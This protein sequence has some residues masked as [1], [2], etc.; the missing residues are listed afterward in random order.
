M[1]LVPDWADGRRPNRRAD[2]G[3]ITQVRD[4]RG[5]DRRQQV[6]VVAA[7]EEDERFTRV[8]DQTIVP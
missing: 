2:D 6:I 3:T 7:Q 4:K 1:S 5:L 8:I